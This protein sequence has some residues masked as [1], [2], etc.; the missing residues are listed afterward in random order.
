MG[1][2]KKKCCHKRHHC[3]HRRR[4]FFVCYVGAPL[5][6]CG[7]CHSCGRPQPC[8]CGAIGNGANGGNGNYGGNHGPGCGCDRCRGSNYYGSGYVT[9]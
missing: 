3:H 1:C 7:I 2:C 8:G 5:C 9:W 4:D 6:G